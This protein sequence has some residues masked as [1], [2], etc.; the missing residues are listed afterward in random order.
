MELTAIWPPYGV[1]ITEGNLELTVMRESDA[2][3]LVDLVLSGIHEPDRMPFIFPWTRRSAE[4]APAEY[5]RFMARNKTRCTPD[6]WDLDFAVRVDGELVGTQGIGGKN[7]PVARTLETGSWLALH[8]QGKGIG[9]R[10]RRAVCAFVFDELGA[11]EVTSHAFADNPAS[12]AVS[13]KVGYRDN[14]TKQ[15][16]R[17]GKLTVEVAFSLRPDDLVRSAS[18]HTTGAEALRRFLGLTRS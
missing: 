8:H 13:R 1:R 15:V 11:T 5:L 3:E 4:A 7:F 10:M 6:D 9:T 12:I 14:G 18:I 2:P 17:E 16:A